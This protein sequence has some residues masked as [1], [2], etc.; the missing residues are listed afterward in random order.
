M[1]LDKQ[2]VRARC[3]RSLSHDAP[4]RRAPQRHLVA[5]AALAPPDLEVDRYGEG[6]LV[7]DFEQEMAAVLG[8]EAAV[9]MPSGTMA[10]QIALRIWA[11]RR[12]LPV[13]AF[14][15]TCHMQLHEENGYARLHGL[16][17]RLVGDR[18]ALL[19]LAD[20]ERIAEPI[21]A[22]LLELPQ[23]EI[24]GILPAWDELVAQCAWARA[25]GIA[26]HLDGARLWETKPFYGREYAEIAGLFDSVYVSLYRGLGGIAGCILAGAADFV[27][28][29]R[30]W[31]RRHGGT[32]ISVYPYVLAA[33]AGFAERIGKMSE[34]RDRAVAIAARLRRIP[35]VEVVPDPPQTNMMH[36]WM[37]GAPERLAQ[38]AL[39]ISD[40]TGVWLF[41]RTMRTGLPS[42]QRIEITVSDGAM[43]IEIDEIGRLIEDML[44]R[45]RRGGT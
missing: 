33:K 29:A 41:E 18:S 11:D 3:E 13:V 40:E 8:K 22:L 9:F 39:E 36:L 6:A 5:L 35:G 2:A 27:A 24:G 12:R 28:E 16:S 19:T 21:A 31:Q 26:V 44:E 23:R 15:P 14:H 17:A 42:W 43:E 38:A 37:R 1:P 10:Q 32:L 4:Q 7:R 20:L 34:Y 25:R 45:A 30:V